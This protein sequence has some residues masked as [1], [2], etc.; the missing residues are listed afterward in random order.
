MSNLQRVARAL[1]EETDPDARYALGRQ[2]AR[3]VLRLLNPPTDEPDPLPTD[4][5]ADVYDDEVP[6]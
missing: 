2:L 4:E 6:F 3:Q 1:L 5:P